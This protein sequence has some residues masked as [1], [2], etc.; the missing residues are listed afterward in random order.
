MVLQ[1]KSWVEPAWYEAERCPWN[2]CW[3]PGT[4]LHKNLK[5]ISMI[6]FIRLSFLQNLQL[7][8]APFPVLA[9]MVLLLIIN[10][11]IIYNNITN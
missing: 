11:I 4:E 10:L 5:K 6:I 3:T 1:M 8:K 9:E 2:Q 7:G